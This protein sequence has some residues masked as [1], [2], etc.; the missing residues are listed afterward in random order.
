MKH[1]FLIFRFL[2]FS[3]GFLLLTANIIL[4]LK[5]YRKLIFQ[6]I[7]LFGLI[8]I[9][10]LSDIAKFYLT[11]NV[12]NYNFIFYLIL[13]NMSNISVSFL[14]FQIPYFINILFTIPFKLKRF[15]FMFGILASISL[16]NNILPFTHKI[17]WEDKIVVHTSKIFSLPGNL[18]FLLV[19]LY[20]VLIGFRYYK[21]INERGK[22]KFL[23]NVAIM[24]AIFIPGIFFEIF[25]TIQSNLFLMLN[26]A[27]PE[28][29]P[30]IFIPLLYGILSLYFTYYFFKS[31]FINKT[32]RNYDVLFRKYNISIREKEVILLLLDG[33]SN[34]EISER[35]FI[36]LG[37]VKNHIYKIFNKI[38]IDNRHALISKFKDI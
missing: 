2:I 35:L 13:G 1:F 36:A 12:P 18:S 10:I 32:S 27:K 19:F 6:F 9:K 22:Q 3:L 29:M 24:I 21:L 20:I 33:L 14:I 11:V 7:I 23:R 16:L 37:T 34:K 31:Y 28:R 8:T 15:N 17:L 30:I 4:Y 5:T 25:G 38:G 26:M